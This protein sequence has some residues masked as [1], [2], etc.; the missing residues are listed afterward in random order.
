VTEPP[1]PYGR[2]TIG[3][4]DIEAVAEVLRGDWLTQ[5]PTVD[6]F[7]AAVAERVEA[8]HAV[9]FA[10]GTAGLHGAAFAAGLGP[11]DLVVTS[12]LSFMASANCARYVGAS[13]GLVDIE[14][15]TWNLD[16]GRLPADADA[17]V[18]VHYAGLPVD[19]T[20]LGRRP[21]VVIEDAAQALGAAT[22][23]GPVGNCVHS[24][25]CMFSLHPVKPITT[26]EGGIVTT[27]D[28]ELAERLRRFRS[29]G[30]VR[31]PEKG[32]WYYEISELGYNYRLTDLQAAL[33]L[34]QLPKL[35]GFIARRNELADRYRVL[36]ADLPVGLPPAAPEGA[37]HG[38]HL[39]PVR[40]ADRARVFEAMRARGIGVQV[41]FVPIHH[42]P[43]SADIGLK[44]G[45][46][47]VCDAVYDELITLP[48]FPTL[49]DADQDRVV[50]SLAALV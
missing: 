34:S 20:R 40:V 4:D 35:D 36:L 32:G 11:G 18:A 42:H 38:Y 16:L 21:R 3:E 50:R 5:G 49:T 31:Q 33:G 1:I 12:P 7:E 19:L 8:R 6:A 26:G 48:L 41:H 14:P 2:Q 39:F 44:P 23:D 15:D 37:V 46:L 30:I 27:N 22:P 9:A 24:D 17:V 13:V 25:L 29:H 43:I 10:N 47:P 45:D 28:D